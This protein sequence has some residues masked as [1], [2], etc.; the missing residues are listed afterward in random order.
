[1]RNSITAI[2]KRGVCLGRARGKETEEEERDFTSNCHSIN[3][4]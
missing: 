4:N 2:Y 3:V 1:M